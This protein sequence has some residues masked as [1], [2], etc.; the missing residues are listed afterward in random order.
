MVSLEKCLA[1]SCESNYLVCAACSAASSRHDSERHQKQQQ[2]PWDFSSRWWIDVLMES[3][4]N[5]SD[6]FQV[7]QF[8]L[9]NFPF[10]Q[11]PISVAACKRAEVGRHVAPLPMCS[12][13]L[14]HASAL[15]F[16]SPPD[17]T[18]DDSNTRRTG[19]IAQAPPVLQALAGSSWHVERAEVV[20]FLSFFLSISFY[21]FLWILSS[22]P[23]Y[24]YI[25][26]RQHLVKL[27]QTKNLK[28]CGEQAV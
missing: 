16:I 11:C 22:S 8:T 23:C 24:T 6:A 21:L 4:Q 18:D 19:R 28:L 9:W 15:K 25:F 20:Q 2:C 26:L 5:I 13:N 3:G 14:C 17:D 1:R 12:W 10:D 7:S 27:R